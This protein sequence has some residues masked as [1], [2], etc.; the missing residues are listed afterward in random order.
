MTRRSTAFGAL[1]RKA[2]GT[3]RDGKTALQAEQQHNVNSAETKREQYWHT[4]LMAEK[5]EELVLAVLASASLMNEAPRSVKEL[6]FPIS[7]AE[8]KVGGLQR[9]VQSVWS[10]P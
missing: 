1:N 3:R 4:V 8:T 5:S 2:R 7:Q 10:A 6:P 9:L